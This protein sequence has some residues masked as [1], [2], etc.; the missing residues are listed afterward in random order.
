M[1]VSCGL[2]GITQNANA[3]TKFFLAAPELSNIANEAH[4]MAGLKS[5]KRT[6]HHELSDTMTKR[7]EKNVLELVDSIKQ[8]CDP[9]AN[10]Y[11]HIVNM[12]TKAVM[13]DTIQQDIIQRNAIGRAM[14]AKF[15]EARVISNEVN[16]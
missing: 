9:F 15:V 13:S 11:D 6:T 4:E 16:I 1:K 7:Q 5:A 12:V 14:V 2:V 10:D 8:F 3:L